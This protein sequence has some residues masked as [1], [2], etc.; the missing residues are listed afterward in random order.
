MEE[1]LLTTKQAADATGLSHWAI[2]W[3]CTRG[4]LGR[5]I[6]RQWLITKS[7]LKDFQAN[8]R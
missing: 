4:K 7:E 1:E 6:G 8:R 5:K 2:R 3:Y